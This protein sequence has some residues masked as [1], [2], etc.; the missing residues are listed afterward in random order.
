[1][2]KISVL[3]I[4]DSAL[5]RELLR[6]IIP[7]DGDM[8]VVDTAPDPFIAREKIKRHNPDV[9]T[10]DVEMPRMDGITFLRN[11]MRL[12]PMPVVMI[13]ALT[14]QGAAKTLEAMALGA[15]GFI[16][17]PRIDLKETLELYGEEIREK[18]RLAAR[19]NFRGAFSARGEAALH[20]PLTGKLHAQGRI[21]GIGASAGG[22]EAIH[23]VVSRMPPDS[24]GILICQHMP[25]LF[26][27]MFAARLNLASALTIELA[28]DGA[29]I[30]PGHAFVAPGDRHLRLQSR[31][32]G[33]YCQLDDGPQV[34]HYRPSVNLM[35][36]S[37]AEQAGNRAIG[38]IL[39]GMGR[40]G[41]E[42]LLAMHRKGAPTIAQDEASSLVWG[43]PGEAVKKGAVDEVVSLEAIPE[44]IIALLK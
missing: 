39:T 31:G 27:G 29:E 1:M 16:T 6:E 25:A 38:V 2:N 7:A 26:T 30:R 3:V 23:A 14:E 32:G 35:F 28:R 20:E 42:G 9:L 44:A 13:S 33:F 24:P 10:L 21:I 41:A 18:I 8:L 5:V 17:K 4:D 34:N 12:R 36:Q 11:L 22:T 19:C 15:V 37:L 43:M 40:D